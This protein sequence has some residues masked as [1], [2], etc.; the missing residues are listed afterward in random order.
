MW[1]ISAWA[2]RCLIVP[3]QADPAMAARVDY[4]EELPRSMKQANQVSSWLEVLGDGRVRVF[5][6]KLNWGKVFG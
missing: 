6:V 4:L 5:S 2:F 3:E 1:V